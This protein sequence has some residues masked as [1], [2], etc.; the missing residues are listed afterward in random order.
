MLDAQKIANVVERV[1]SRR[2]RGP[3]GFLFG[4]IGWLAIVKIVLQVLA[5][6]MAREGHAV[7]ATLRTGPGDADVRDE[8]DAVF[9]TG[10]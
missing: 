1:A 2:R 6:L 3:F 5:E 9:G 8:I 7:P 4:G 10:F